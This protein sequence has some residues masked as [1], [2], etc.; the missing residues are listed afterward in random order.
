MLSYTSAGGRVF[1]THYSYE[2]LI[3]NG[4]LANSATWSPTQNG[5]GSVTATIDTSFKK[6]QDFA[7]WLKVVGAQNGTGTFVIQNSREDL[8]AVASTSQQFLYTLD[9]SPQTPLQFGFN[10]PVGSPASQ[11]CGRVVFSDFHVIDNGTLSNGTTFP[12][13]CTTAPMT[14]QEKA[15]E[16]QLLD[17]ASCI[18]PAPQNCKPQTCTDQK[19]SCGPAGDGCGQQIDCGKC[20]AP[21]TCGG[22]GVYGQCGYPDAGKCIP[23]TC[24]QRGF[25]CGLNGDGCGNPIDCGPCPAPSICGGGG[26]PN[27]CGGP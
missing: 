25:T 24:A 20:P 13:E 16:F 3:T 19:I 14:P 22:G 11:Q 5:P 18:Q 9:T 15:L 17:L 7:S 1:A 23:Q 4:S 26:V 8:A 6:G 21:Q 2:W 12:N 10:T 27:V